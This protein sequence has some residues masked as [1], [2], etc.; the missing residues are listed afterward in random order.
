MFTSRWFIFAVFIKFSLFT[1]VN[2]SLLRSMDIL[3][4]SRAQ[5]KTSNSVFLIAVQPW[6]AL[7]TGHVNTQVNCLT[8]GEHFKINLFDKILTTMTSRI[9]IYS[10]VL[11]HSHFAYCNHKNVYRHE[12]AYAWGGGFKVQNQI[13]LRTKF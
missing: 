2:V 4:R 8:G 5:F 1:S 9:T 11:N 6:R 3:S 12:R 7:T 13:W 10:N